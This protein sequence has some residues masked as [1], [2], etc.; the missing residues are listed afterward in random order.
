MWN[1]IL[2]GV[3]AVLLAAGALQGQSRRRQRRQS[4]GGEFDYYLLALSWA[5]D[6]CA[7]PSGR[8]DPRE[9]GTGRRLG[10]VVHGLWPQ[11]ESGRGPERCAPAS[12]VAHGIVQTMLA[13]IPTES[14]V[15]HEW[16][17]HGTCSGLSAADYF[18]AVRKARDSIAVPEELKQPSSVVQ[19]SPA[20][21]EARF[22][23]ANPSF[24]REAFAL[25]C[26]N[27]GELQE[28]RVCFDKSLVPRPCGAR[29]DTCRIPAVTV[30]PV[31]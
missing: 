3:V 1:R 5:P 23:A 14:L 8:K 15:Q 30:L 21:V 11:S 13:Y 28:A 7:Q 26:Y 19:L 25:S 16:T 27:D 4:A 31:R 24:P 17:N 29:A 2:A 9:C 22:A 18:G 10:F 20:Q 6:F 12:P